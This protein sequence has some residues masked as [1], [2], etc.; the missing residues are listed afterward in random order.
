[1]TTHKKKYNHKNI[2]DKITDKK[3]QSKK[4]LI[5]E[6]NSNVKKTGEQ[7]CWSGGG[8]CLTRDGATFERESISR[9]DTTAGADEAEGGGV[10]KIGRE[11]R[12][13]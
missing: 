8:L 2:N 12:R 9:E 10:K 1:M 4:R 11:T 5:R 3:R 7:T 13:E 6:K